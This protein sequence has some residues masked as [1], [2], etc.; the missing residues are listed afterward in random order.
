MS[1]SHRPLVR[2]ASLCALVAVSVAGVT[3]CQNDNNPPMGSISAPRGGAA[4]LPKAEAPKKGADAKSGMGIKERMG[5]E[6]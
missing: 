6:K 5:L 2:V 3:G 4:V 1:V